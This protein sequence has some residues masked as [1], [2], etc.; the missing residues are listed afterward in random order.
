MNHVMKLVVILFS[1]LYFVSA[2]VSADEIAD[3][4]SVQENGTATDDKEKQATDDKKKEGEEL[5]EEEEPD[6]D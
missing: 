6:C 2:P 1:L 4:K 3:E 5:E